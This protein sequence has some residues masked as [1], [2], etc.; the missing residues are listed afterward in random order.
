MLS[1][2]QLRYIHPDDLP[3]FF[4]GVT[5][6]ES[7]GTVV[8][9]GKFGG[10]S[11]QYHWVEAHVRQYISAG[12]HAD[13]EIS[14]LRIVD[15]QVA[16]EQELERRARWDS[17]TGLLNRAE[18]LER[19]ESRLTRGGRRAT[20]LA[21][22]YCDLDGFKS[23]NDQFGHATGDQV[24]AAL[25]GRI[26]E[27]V[28]GDDLVARIGGDEILIVLDGVDT[29][30]DAVTVA[31]T[32]RSEVRVPVETDE[33]PMSAT[34][35]IGVVLA[36]PDEPMDSLLARADQAMYQAKLDGR[37]RVVAQG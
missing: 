8:R 3:E 2:D 15:D 10:L 28:R 32:V 20:G 19:L 1:A 26:R 30:A 7:G 36:R 29:L 14:S 27:S 9:R 5:Q 13:G 33:G 34:I 18:L 25:A 16:A 22:A 23:V 17:V 37:D 35:S 6:V 4:R 24:L 12:G 21:L 31:E 11:G